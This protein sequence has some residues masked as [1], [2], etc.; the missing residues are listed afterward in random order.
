[1]TAW[2]V[3]V[4]PDTASISALCAARMRSANS[5]PFSRPK[6]VVSLEVSTTTFVMALAS[7]VMVTVTS[8]MPVAVA[9]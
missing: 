4:T 1:M 7:K 9:E 6:P 8:P 3:T 2:L 5:P